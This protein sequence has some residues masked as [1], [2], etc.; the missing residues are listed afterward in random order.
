MPA[1]NTGKVVERKVAKVVVEQRE[2]VIAHDKAVV[3]LDD[4][5]ARELISKFEKNKNDKSALEAEYKALQTEIYALLGYKKV[6][7]KWI[8]VAEQGTIEGV[9]VVKV[10]S[11]SRENFKKD[12]FLQANPELLELVMSFTEENSFTRLDTIK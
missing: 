7:D 1:K 4:T 11:Q 10:S 3:A 5:N 6:G 8:G 2:A 12:K 9:A